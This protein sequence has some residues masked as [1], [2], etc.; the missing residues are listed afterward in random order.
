MIRHAIFTINKFDF[1]HNK[2][3]KR[4]AKFVQQA[5]PHNIAN[6]ST[7]QFGNL[8]C[9]S[10]GLQWIRHSSLQ[11]V[12]PR[13]QINSTPKTISV[14]CR[15]DHKQQFCYLSFNRLQVVCAIFS[16]SL[17]RRRHGSKTFT[18]TFLRA[19]SSSLSKWS[20]LAGKVFWVADESSL[21]L[22]L[23]LWWVACRSMNFISTQ[24]A[25]EACVINSLIKF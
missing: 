13:G 19:S 25:V 24:R 23:A 8:K 9:F 1:I 20:A 17:I 22:E 15:F 4:R 12:V 18:L 6:T 7:S 3:L 14:E 16:L 5:S 21:S 10:T 2:S 11:R